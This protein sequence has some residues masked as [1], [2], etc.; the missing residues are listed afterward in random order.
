[1]IHNVALFHSSKKM[2][3]KAEKKGAKNVLFWQKIIFICY[4]LNYFR[5]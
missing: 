4:D 5:F 1:M 3:K 2:E